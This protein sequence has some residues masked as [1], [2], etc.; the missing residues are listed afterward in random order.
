MPD[1]PSHPRRPPSACL[2]ARPLLRRSIV[3]AVAAACSLGF[4][5][6]RELIGQRREK[7]E[8]MTP[9]EKQQLRRKLDR[10]QGYPPEE[11]QRMRDLEAALRADPEADALRQVLDRYDL[12]LTELSAAE[13]HELLILEGPERI[14]R[15][16]Q[17]RGERLG[18]KDREAV[19]K[20]LEHLERLAWEN[21][22]PEE[23]AKIRK[24]SEPERQQRQRRRPVWYPNP[25]EYVLNEQHL[26]KLRESLSKWPRRRLDEAMKIEE[27]K[28]LAAPD[29]RD[30][31]GGHRFDRSDLRRLLF[32]WSMQ[33]WPA[34]RGPIRPPASDEQVR[35]VQEAR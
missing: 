31:A 21:M 17:L 2:A 15:I 10:F 27:A 1:V 35:G 19:L 14:E 25:A 33:T 7:V 18:E 20:W 32:G 3:L 30:E 13:R 5:D 8:R 11:Q 6:P 9:Q 28:R 34:E 29:Q 24:I 16:K 26:A 4:S 23:K 22:A 12:W